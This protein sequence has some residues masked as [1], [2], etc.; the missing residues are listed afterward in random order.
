MTILHSQ[1][2]STAFSASNLVFFLPTDI[3]DD[4]ER[5]FDIFA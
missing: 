2:F 1:M 4:P 3:F 5:D